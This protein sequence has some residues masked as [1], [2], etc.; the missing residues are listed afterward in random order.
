[1]IGCFDLFI[2]SPFL[3]YVLLIITI[4]LRNCTNMCTY[5][6]GPSAL[7]SQNMAGK[8][9]SGLIFVYW[10]SYI[11]LLYPVKGSYLIGRSCFKRISYC[12]QNWFLI[13][14]LFSATPF[15]G[16]SSSI[17]GIILIWFGKD[18][19]S[20]VPTDATLP[21]PSYLLSF[22]SFLWKIHTMLTADLSC[23]RLICMI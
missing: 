10:S 15:R 17:R 8:K 19:M 2:L 4:T 9:I 22:F 21:G 5:L 1:M 7:C 13:L 3:L 20:D 23:C 16:P 12:N 6:T 11:H 18:F 14:I